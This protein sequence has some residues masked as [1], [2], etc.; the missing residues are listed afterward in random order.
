MS[1]CSLS[2]K[3]NEVRVTIFDTHDMML[4]R[5]EYRRSK[6]KAVGLKNTWINIYIPDFVFIQDLLLQG[7]GN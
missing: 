1:L 5:P 7:C 6:F 2:Q 4:M 3:S